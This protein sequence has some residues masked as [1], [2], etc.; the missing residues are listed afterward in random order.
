MVKRHAAIPMYIWKLH[1]EMTKNECINHSSDGWSIDDVNFTSHFF[2]LKI[3]GLEVYD[4]FDF[5]KMDQ[6]RMFFSKLYRK[7]SLILFFFQVRIT[8]AK[9]HVLLLISFYLLSIFVWSTQKIELLTPNFLLRS[10]FLHLFCFVFTQKKTIY[11]WHS[12][13]P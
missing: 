4:G 3:Y 7:A 5:R 10:V 11:S 2:F 12:E 6:S 8:L 13:C 9:R 1:M